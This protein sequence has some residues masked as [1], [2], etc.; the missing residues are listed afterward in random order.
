MTVINL[1]PEFEEAIEKL[2]ERKPWIPPIRPN[3]ASLSEHIQLIEDVDDGE[4]LLARLNRLR[5][6]AIA[7]DTEFRFTRAAV[8]LSRGRSW[9]DPRTIQ[10]L[11]LS[12][13]VWLPDSDIVITFAF[14]LR[15]RPRAPL[16][17]RLLRLR[18]VFVAH[19][20][21]AEFKTVWAL[22]L[23]PVLPQTYDTWVA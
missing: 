17:A 11:I 15:R 22:G 14:E 19:Y 18:T 23:D 3:I 12:S 13:A 10:P 7:I 6:G 8:E 16:I 1:L 5:I 4:A 21:N 9:Q 20:F 2:S